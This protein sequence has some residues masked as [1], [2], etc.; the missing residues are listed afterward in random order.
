MNF[1]FRIKRSFGMTFVQVQIWKAI[2]WALEK[3]IDINKKLSMK[4]KH[5]CEH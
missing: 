4:H 3:K 5:D 1:T 2:V